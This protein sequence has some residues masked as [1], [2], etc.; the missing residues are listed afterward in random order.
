MLIA[1][2]VSNSIQ[3]KREKQE[4]QKREDEE[5]EKKNRLIFVGSPLWPPSDYCARDLNLS[6]DK[7]LEMKSRNNRNNVA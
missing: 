2:C 1:R 4:R 6:I 7:R 5:K 3:R